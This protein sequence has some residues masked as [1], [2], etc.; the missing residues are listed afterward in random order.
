MKVIEI[1]HIRLIQ[2]LLA[3]L[4]T[5]SY[6]N[7]DAIMTASWVMPVSYIP[8]VVAVAISPE[9]YTHRIVKYSGEYAVNIMTYEYLDNVHCAG[10]ISKKNYPDKF[11]RV[12]LTPIRAKK[13]NSIVLKEA[14]GVLECKV[15]DTL[16]TGDHELFVADVIYAYIN[17]DKAYSTHWIPAYYKPL[18]YI[19]EGHYLTID[20]NTVKKM[21]MPTE[22][23]D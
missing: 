1:D 13:I 2:P 8:P 5:S 15:K 7:D 21:D 9:R 11:I 6:K 4:I 22:D 20:S 12:G 19:S 18:L 23:R 3:T 16:I 10:T 17:N 14:I